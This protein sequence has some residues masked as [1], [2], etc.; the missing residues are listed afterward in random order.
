MAKIFIVESDINILNIMAVK[1]FELK[2]VV[3]L[4]DCSVKN[5]YGLL[6]LG[7]YL[8]KMNCLVTY[9]MI[10]P[11]NT[12]ELVAFSKGVRPDDVF[13]VPTNRS[14][15]IF[16]LTLILK[17]ICRV[18]YVESDS[19]FYELKEGY[20]V[21]LNMDDFD[22][23]IDD[24]VNQYGGQILN[25]NTEVFDNPVADQVLEVILR[26]TEL[27]D[28][29]L[30][31]VPIKTDVVNRRL[32]RLKREMINHAE[33]KLLDEILDIMIRNGICAYHSKG[34]KDFIEFYNI[35][36]KE[37]I[38]KN[39]TWLEMVTY[40]A[41]KS[42]AEVSDVGA[43]ISFQWHMNR[44]L[45]KNEVDVIGIYRHKLIII[46]CKNTNSHNEQSLYELYTHSERLDE[47][48]AVKIMVTTGEP[49]EAFYQRAQDLKI[50]IVIFNGDM[51]KFVRGLGVAIARG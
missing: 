48:Q 5:D 51:E 14:A 47:N 24:Y 12:D 37:F 2:T 11:Y 31:P 41:I 45:T 46:S 49:V 50:H 38:S 39:G 16:N 25:S 33:G 30:T 36:F 22:L 21:P 1:A 27:Y 29:L 40:K 6:A 15:Y 17:G 18:A 44:R 9:Q 7:T 43:S 34:S 26:N 13:I 19:D 32:V 35:D 23:N 8:K 4:K 3:I 42:L 20:F 28:N 10:D